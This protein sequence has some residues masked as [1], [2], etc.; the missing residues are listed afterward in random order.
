MILQ[1]KDEILN[2]LKK[3][4]DE[5]E[6]NIQNNYYEFIDIDDIS[7]QA[8]LAHLIQKDHLSDDYFEE[9]QKKGHQYIV[10]VNGN[11]N[12]SFRSLKKI[13]IQFYHV[14][15]YFSCAHN[16]LI[17]LEGCPQYVGGNFYCDYN[18]LTLLQYCPQ[19][20]NGLLVGNHNKLLSLEYFPEKI[21]D[22][23]SL[24]N[25]ELLKY[26][27]DSND[28]NIKTMSDEDF[29]KQQDFKFWQ[30]FH[31][32]EKAKKENKRITDDLQFNDKIENI[33]LNQSRIKKV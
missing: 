27:K 28:I 23:I 4:D 21:N 9:I 15:G 10:N 11:C 24:N 22:D 7:N 31:L 20:V 6:K 25:N 5:F 3:Y 8:L 30:Q 16:Q 14:D 17:S 12:I 13:L 2:W 1:K 33:Q 29:L 19:Y 32:E 18:Q 26:K